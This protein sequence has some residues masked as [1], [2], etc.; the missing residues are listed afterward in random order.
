MFTGLTFRW[1]VFFLICSFSVIRCSN[2]PTS[3]PVETQTLDLSPTSL[4]LTDTDIPATPSPGSSQTQLSETGTSSPEPSQAQ[5]PETKTPS[6]Q[7]NPTK[8]I[9]TQA[10]ET[11]SPTLDPKQTRPAE[12]ETSGVTPTL[13]SATETQTPEANIRI[14][15]QTDWVDYG[16]ILEAGAEGEWDLYLWGGF[17]FSVIKRD[18]TYYLYYQG[19]SDYRTE[20]DET[21]LWR[22]I[23]VATSQ[24]GIHFAKY[25][26]NPILTWFPT[27]NGEEGAVSSGVTLGE[28]G[29]T[30]LFYGA[31]TQEILSI[32]HADVRV[33]ASLDGF[34]FN[35]LGIVLDR[36]DR[37]VWGSGDEL[38][39]VDAIY[40]SGQWI[41]YYI[42]NGTAESGLLGVAYGD[43][44]NALTHS[45]VVTSRGQPLSVWGT[46]GHVKLT[47][48]TYALILNNVRE[49]RTEVRLVSLQ[50]PNI[51][52]DPV[53]VYQFD[54]VQQA[55]LLLDEENEIW[56]MYYRTFANSYG[57]KLA[58]AGDE[59]LPA[60][61]T[62]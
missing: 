7:P 28:Q 4:H 41:V 34:S 44:Y 33:A 37:S 23:G 24:D 54:E 50:A 27:Q 29:E 43:Q 38:F 16:T 47:Q 31:N 56:F 26:G 46:A 3:Q 40:D 13:P 19:S 53:A 52:S 39:S 42:P 18:S 22:A 61:S 5:L 21:V 35:D 14:P 58:P 62:P 1:I 9:E 2:L 15:S 8:L 49:Q 10:G 57:V 55:V 17:A 11:Q 45:S 12:T 36:T 30:M 32:V 25:E 6:L 60:P 48:D 59:P 51:I 20:F